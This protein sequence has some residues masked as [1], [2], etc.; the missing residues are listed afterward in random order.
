MAKLIW[1]VFTPN[2]WDSFS[3]ESWDSFALGIPPQHGIVNINV[4]RSFSLLDYKII[5]VLKFL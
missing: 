5:S 3:A 2:E 4:R 1:E